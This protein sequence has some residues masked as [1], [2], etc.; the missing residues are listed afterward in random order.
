MYRNI[1]VPLDGSSF[2]EHALPHALALARRSGANLLLVT[3]S[4][5]LA[6]AYTEGLYFSSTELEEEITARHHRYLHDVAILLRQ[7]HEVPITVAVKHGE[8][9][10]VLVKMIEDGEAD[11]VVMATHGRGTLGR[12]WLGSV[13]DEMIRQSNVPLLLIR[14]TSDKPN[15]QVEPPFQSI[16]LALDGSEHA[17]QILQHAERLVKLNPK[18]KLILIRAI[19][20]ALPSLGAVD[21]PEAPKEANALLKRLEELQ[22]KLRKDALDYLRSVASKI[23]AHG[24]ETEVDVIVEDQ[25]ALA[26]L[27]EA[28]MKK[29]SMIAIETHRRTGISRFLRGSVTEKVLR[30]STIPVL[31][32]SSPGA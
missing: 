17:E 9:A 19:N 3:V 23:Q 13:A 18:A 27:K 11:L 31:V 10:P 25:P 2:A 15:L 22:D 29:V 30:G 24:I 14:P 4:T 16:L 5:P 1:L 28:E 26:I 8:V 21:P 20:T 12:F 6:E 7:I 32:H